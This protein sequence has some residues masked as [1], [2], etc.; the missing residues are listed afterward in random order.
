M[1]KVAIALALAV[2]FPLTVSEIASR[3]AEA[4][5][6]SAQA[7]VFPYC[8]RG[9]PKEGGQRCSYNTRAQCMKSASGRG[10]TCV[11]NPRYR[12]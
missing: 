1:R 11:R 4:S 2:F 5:E 6:I 7:R 12:A 8:L 3:A 10:G 9:A